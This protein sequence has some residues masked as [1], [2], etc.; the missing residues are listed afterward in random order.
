[1][2]TSEK[3]WVIEHSW[4]CGHCKHTNRGRDDKCDQCGKPIDST[5][6]ETIPGD[7]S[8]ENRVKDTTR[9]D[10]T[11]P[12]WVCDCCDHRN[13]A[14]RIACTECGSIGLKQKFDEEGEPYHFQEYSHD[15]A[16]PQIIS[17]PNYKKPPPEPTSV[18]VGTGYRQ[19]TIQVPQKPVEPLK[20]PG[21]VEDDEIEDCKES[22]FSANF[23]AILLGIGGIFGVIGLIWLCVWL[24]A[25]HDT[26][27]SVQDTTWHYHVALLERRIYHGRAW[28]DQMQAH[29]FNVT[30]TTE[31][32]SYHNCDPYSCNYRNESYSC[33]CSSVRTGES[34]STSC[35]SNG[36]RSSTCRQSCRPTYSTRCSTCS[37]TVH[38][39]CY[40]RCPDYDQMCSYDYPSWP[41]IN[42]ADATQHNHTPIRPSLIAPRGVS[43]VG[44]N[45]LIYLQSGATQCTQDS[46]EFQVQ[47]DAGEAGH[48][49]INPNTLSEYDLYQT[50]AR[51]N[52]QYNHAGMFRPINRQ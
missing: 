43:C 18:S 23:N 34:C 6:I 11:R 26:T 35:S 40:H 10:D 31:I 19:T 33:N 9:F 3:T 41:A 36:N 47:F 51:W 45:E 49:S 52:V 2:S 48:Y 17:N 12:D 37:R 50:R 29:S 14:K 42:H 28:R 22:W 16:I 1:M 4:L 8:Y 30:C 32:R 46:I 20:F 21:P 27:A 25:W 39:T 44:D 5:H 13:P 15:S 24:F 7:M 38:D